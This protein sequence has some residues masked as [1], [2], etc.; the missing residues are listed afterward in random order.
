MLK[1]IEEYLN[2]M[3]GEV[4]SY[5]IYSPEID[6]KNNGY[7]V[8]QSIRVIM[9]AG[10]LFL[11]AF[12]GGMISIFELLFNHRKKAYGIS[13]A[14]GA[15]YRTVFYEMFAEVALLNGIGMF[16]GIGIGYIVTYFVDMGI[17]IG[18]I[19]VEGSIV[20]FIASISVYLLITIIVSGKSYIKIKQR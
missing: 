5:R 16:I 8:K 10:I 12:L 2:K 15:D 3:H 6:L 14:C 19:K 17:M 11:I 1:N 20:S 9:Q 18:Y 4:Y 13:L 7:K